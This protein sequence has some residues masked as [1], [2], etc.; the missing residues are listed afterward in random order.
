[1]GPKAPRGECPPQPHQAT[2]DRGILRPVEARTVSILYSDAQSTP[3]EYSGGS[4]GSKFTLKD[5]KRARESKKE[6]QEDL[7]AAGRIP[8]KSS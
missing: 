3:Q 7:K 6:S 8:Q 4:T 5:R 1:M 2:Q